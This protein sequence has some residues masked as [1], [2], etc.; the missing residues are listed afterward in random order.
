MDGACLPVLVAL[1]GNLEPATLFNR[2][3]SEQTD[4]CARGR[5]LTERGSTPD[6]DL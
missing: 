3:V 5:R 6:P 2:G 1:A 4:C